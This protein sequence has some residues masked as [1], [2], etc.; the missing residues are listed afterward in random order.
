[1][2]DPIRSYDAPPTDE[3]VPLLDLVFVIGRHLKLLVALPLLIGCVSLGLTF[4]LKPTFTAQAVFLP[5]QQQTG[6]SAALQQLGGLAALAGAAGGMK[7]PADQ[8]VG[9]MRS[10]RVR[11]TLIERNN[12]MKVYDVSSRDTALEILESRTQISL[13][14]KDGL[15]S[16]LVDDTDPERAA[17]L[18]NAYVEELSRLTKTLAL[19]EAQQRRVF[20]ESQLEAAKVKLNDAQI[21]LQRTGFNESSMRLELRSAADS[22]AALRAQVTAAEVRLGALRSQLTAQAPDYKAA[23]AQVQSL[24]SEL[25]R[26]EQSNPSSGSDQYLTQ[27]REFKYQEALFE[28]FA[29]QFEMA[30]LDEARDGTLIQVIDAATPPEFK[31][32]PRRG[33]IAV[34][35]TLGSGLLLLM[36]ILIRHAWR[37][38]M[39]SPAGQARLARWRRERA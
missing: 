6:T 22:Y 17:R 38:Q 1:M 33:L 34:L 36:F 11:G 26:L 3:E 14:K 12:L 23:E 25:R 4:L 16:V 32:K 18:A 7:N 30:K 24:R 31:S 13:G 37:I 8:Y 15:V 20:F 35:A 19:S 9:L 5:P 39:H 2:N 27:Y 21:Q 28:L 29:R 10:V